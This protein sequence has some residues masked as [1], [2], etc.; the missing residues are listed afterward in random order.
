M[1]KLNILPPNDTRV[2]H[3]S[4]EGNNCLVRTGTINDKILSFFNSVLLACSKNL[5]NMK[6][7]ERENL[8][9]KIRDNIFVKITKNQWKINGINLFKKII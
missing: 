5:K 1:D 8:C 2:F 9:K 3:S 4:I 6:L 7:D